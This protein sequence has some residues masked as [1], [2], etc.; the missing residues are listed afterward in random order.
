M[1]D[2]VKSKNDDLTLKEFA[3]MQKD[4][5]YKEVVYPWEVKLKIAFAISLIFMIL[6]LYCRYNDVS[7]Y[8]TI[9][10]GVL[11]LFFTIRVF[12]R[13]YG[14]KVFQNQLE[15]LESSQDSFIEIVEGDDK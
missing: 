4:N 2:T 14:L 5:F 7:S 3:K 13:H 6:F 1:K 9:T 8:V 12:G 15:N 11:A 10:S